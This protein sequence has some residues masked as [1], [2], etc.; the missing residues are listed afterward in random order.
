MVD[1]AHTV[2]DCAIDQF[3]PSLHITI[4]NLHILQKLRELFSE[5]KS[6]MATLFEPSMGSI[7]KRILRQIC[8]ENK[9]DGSRAG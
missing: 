1:A 4:S 8:N 9:Q 3:P 7:V 5:F 2:I 6:L